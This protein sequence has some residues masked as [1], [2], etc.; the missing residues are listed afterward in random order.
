MMPTFPPPPLRFRTVGFP[1]YGSKASLSAR[2]CPGR[3]EVKPTPGIPPSAPEFTPRL[4]AESGDNLGT[5]PVRPETGN[6]ARS[7]PRTTPLTPG[8]LSSG[9]V[10]LSRPSSPLRPHA[11]VSQAPGDF[12]G[13]PLIPRAFAGR[14]RRKRPARPSR[15]SLSVC[16]HVPRTLRRRGR[17]RCPLWSPAALPGFPEFDAGRPPQPRLCQ[18]HPASIRFDAA[19]LTS[20]CGPCLC[21]ALRAGY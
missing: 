7:A 13:S 11:P 20:C 8:V 6:P 17:R 1:Q 18:L 2:V 19:S 15:L 4:R 14:A 21:P 9:R 16:R 10:V 12:T 5:P 3:V